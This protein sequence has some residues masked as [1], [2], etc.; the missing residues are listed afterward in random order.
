[1]AHRGTSTHS[2][3]LTWWWCLWLLS[4]YVGRVAM[5]LTLRADTAP[6]RA[7]SAAAY[8][9]SDAVDIAL[10]VVALMLVT[11]IAKAYSS[12]YV[13][14]PVSPNAGHSQPVISPVTSE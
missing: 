5:K 4:N 3:L 12:N 13:E 11:A 8:V 14:E 1:M 7:Q 2:S 9:A 6:A 10:N